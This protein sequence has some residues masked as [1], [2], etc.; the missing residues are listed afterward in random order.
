MALTRQ[1]DSSQLI[2]MRVLVIV[3]HPDDAESHAGGTVATLARQGGY[4]AYLILTDGDKGSANPGITPECLARMRQEEQ[5]NAARVLGVVAVD[6]LGWPDCEVEDTRASRMAVTAA[7]RRHRPDLVI[8]QSPH[9]TTRLGLSHRDHRVA[10]SLALDCIESFAG[11]PLCYPELLAQ[12]L[13]PHMVTEVYLMTSEHG[14]LAVDISETIDLKI[15]ALACHASQIADPAML[16]QHVRQRSAALGTPHGYRYAEV[17]E[18]VL[19]EARASCSASRIEG[20][21]HPSNS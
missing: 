20:L 3:A 14:D 5:R 1:S 13:E 8:T 21:I 11:H 4:V 6:F 12:G 17:F 19:T 16:E 7:I 9:R 2:G 10:G 15:R 18:R